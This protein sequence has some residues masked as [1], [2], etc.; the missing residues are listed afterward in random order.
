MIVLSSSG[1]SS[2]AV[3]AESGTNLCGSD[4]P[5]AAPPPQPASAKLSASAPKIQRVTEL[6]VRPGQSAGHLDLLSLVVHLGGGAVQ[7]LAGNSQPHYDQQF[8]CAERPN[9][10][11]I[12]DRR[13]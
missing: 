9:P 3:S 13:V 11:R 8:G 7:G 5:D 2:D 10:H 1:V 6:R 12:C 4:A